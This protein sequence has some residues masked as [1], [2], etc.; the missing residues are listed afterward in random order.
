M[1]IGKSDE[2]LEQTERWR[3]MKFIYDRTADSILV[4]LAEE[5]V[6]ETKEIGPGVYAEYDADGRLI[7][8]EALK[9]SERY[10]LSGVEGAVPMAVQPPDVPKI[11]EMTAEE[12]KALV[13]RL[14]RSS[15]ELSRDMGP[16][17]PVEED[18]PT[19]A[20]RK[21]QARELIDTVKR[22]SRDM[23]PR[24]WARDDLYDRPKR[25]YQ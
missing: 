17:A 22:F 12:R 15:E 4:W 14:M 20:E 2:W 21:A 3:G 7:A 19:A 8:V 18:R 11:A 5:K 24:T 13:A 10:D 9:A 6:T 25:Y 23:S 16:D 1:I